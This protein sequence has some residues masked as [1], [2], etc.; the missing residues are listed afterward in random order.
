MKQI[1][2]YLTLLRIVLVPVFVVVYYT[3]VPSWNYW[4]AGVFILASLT[5]LLD[6]KLA[7]KWEVVSDFGKLVDPIADKLLV[8][9]ALLVLMDWGKLPAW[10]AVILIG[11]EFIISGFRLLAANKGVVI[12]AGWS[13]KIKTVVQLVGISIVLLKNP[14]FGLIGLDMG[15][16]LIYI[17]VALSIYSCAEYIVK[18]RKLLEG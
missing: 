11:R 14:L 3:A 4:A 7:R 17:S 5:D 15:M 9:A 1:P 6:G 8:T 13:G 2:N 12:A 10:V 16:I 18:N